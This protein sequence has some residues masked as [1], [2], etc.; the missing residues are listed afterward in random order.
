M[1]KTI[2]LVQG[3]YYDL[4]LTSLDPAIKSVYSQYSKQLRTHNQQLK[5]IF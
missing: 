2:E 3:A 1:D 4:G 5:H